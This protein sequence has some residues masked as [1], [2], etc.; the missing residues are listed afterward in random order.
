MRGVDFRCID[1]PFASVPRWKKEISQEH[2]VENEGLNA[3]VA[4]HKGIANE[5]HKYLKR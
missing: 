3:N 4:E 1:M 2:L 5:R